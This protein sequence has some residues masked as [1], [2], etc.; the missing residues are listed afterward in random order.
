MTQPFHELDSVVLVNDLPEAGLCAGD[1][2]AVVHV[3]AADAFEV[4]LV[5]AT[6]R[7]LALRTLSPDDVRI[8][9][10][11]DVLAARPL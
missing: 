10:D 4:E 5:T 2:G 9:S 8:A 6:G 7:T 1:L 3:H 11:D